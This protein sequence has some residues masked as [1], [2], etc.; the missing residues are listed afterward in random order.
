MLDLFCGAGGCSAGYDRAGFDCIGIDHEAQPNYPFPFIKMDALWALEVLDL[1]KFAAIHA[2][3]P[4]QNHSNLRYRSERRRLDRTE[5]EPVREALNDT[6]LPWIIENVEQ[7]PLID[8]VTLCGSMF[9]LGVRR[10]RLFETSFPLGQPECRHE[11]QTPQYQ[12]PDA[13]GKAQFSGVVNVYGKCSYKGE[14]EVREKA[15]DIDWMSNYELTQA[16]PPAYTEY[17]GMQAHAHLR[18]LDKPSFVTI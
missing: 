9:A 14:R 15:M 5:I 11:L 7:A 10:H 2:S 17:V 3:P 8:A 6:G 13:R 16:V 18:T 12:N 1:S 4:C